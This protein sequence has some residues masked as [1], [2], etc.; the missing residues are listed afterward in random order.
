[1]G[2]VNHSQVMEWE[3][4]EAGL[5][6]WVFRGNVIKKWDN[7]STAHEY[8]EKMKFLDTLLAGK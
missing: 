5:T 6:M 4:W 1:M 3:T 2:N 8:V 7:I